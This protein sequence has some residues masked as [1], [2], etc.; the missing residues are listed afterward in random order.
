MRIRKKKQKTK[1]MSYKASEN[2][3]HLDN[4]I[5]KKKKDGGKNERI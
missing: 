3:I 1:R 2:C 5:K 4:F